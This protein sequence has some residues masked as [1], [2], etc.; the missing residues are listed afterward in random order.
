M[1]STLILAVTGMHCGSCGITIDEAVE[2]IPGVLSSSTHTRKER[3]VVE[4][5]P[6]TDL[7]AVQAAITAAGYSVTPARVDGS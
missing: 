4:Y 7:A 1:S 6:G 5:D 3:T 2:A